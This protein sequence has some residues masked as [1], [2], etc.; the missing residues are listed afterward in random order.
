MLSQEQ[1]LFDTRASTLLK[2]NHPSNVRRG[3]SAS[4]PS[5]ALVISHSSFL[6]EMNA[7]A[8]DARAADDASRGARFLTL[9]LVADNNMF[10]FIMGG[11]GPPVCV[12]FSLQQSYPHLILPHCQAR[13]GEG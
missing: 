7:A 13:I 8:S 2:P 5:D 10:M 9:A 1:Y 12:N 11:F 6:C 4:F 3:G